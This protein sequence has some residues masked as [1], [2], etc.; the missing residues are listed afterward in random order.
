MSK[1][2]GF[3]TERYRDVNYI[4]WYCKKTGDVLETIKLGGRTDDN[5]SA[6][7]GSRSPEASP[8]SD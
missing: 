4:H 8:G 6:Q 5:N 1:E 3:S 7:L 2:L